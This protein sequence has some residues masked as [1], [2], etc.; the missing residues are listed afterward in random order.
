MECRSCHSGAL[1]GYTA[2]I[3]IRPAFPVLLICLNCGFAESCYLTE[4]ERL[5]LLY[6]KANHGQSVDHG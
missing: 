4:G 3:H 6:N 2:E 1:S 5:E